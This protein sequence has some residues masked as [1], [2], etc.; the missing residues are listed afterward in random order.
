M[1]K[2]GA[3]VVVDA[4]A[5]L[6][7]HR[8]GC[9]EALARG[10]SSAN[11]RQSAASTKAALL[12]LRMSRRVRRGG[13]VVECTALEMRHTR[14]GIGSSNL[15]LSAIKS[16]FLLGFCLPRDFAGL[17]RNFR[18]L[19]AASSRQRRK[20][21]F[22]GALGAVFATETPPRLS[23]VPNFKESVRRVRRLDDSLSVTPHLQRD[24]RP[25]AQAL[26]PELH[27][28]RACT[29]AASL[30]SRPVSVRTSMMIRRRRNRS[31]PSYR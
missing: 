10:Y 22:R 16:L 8:D 20:R 11:W 19:P 14:K 18:V 2:R 25:A 13:R 28:P 24:G 17:P 1:H 30:S 23:A 26:I 31:G 15:P 9:R 27:D 6:T 29:R 21:R 4:L 12:D 5:A 7:T 3:A